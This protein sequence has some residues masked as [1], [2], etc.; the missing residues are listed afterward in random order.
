MTFEKEIEQSHPTRGD[1][2]YR[3][4]VDELAMKLVGERHGKRELINLVRWLIMD[5]AKSAQDLIHKGE[6]E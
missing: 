1:S 6:S 4:E 3:Y 5:G 2:D